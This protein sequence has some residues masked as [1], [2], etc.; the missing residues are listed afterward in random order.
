MDEDRVRAIVTGG[1]PKLQAAWDRAK[2]N[3]RALDSCA[4]PHAFVDITPEK[5]FGKTYRCS[6]CDGEADSQARHWYEL[7]L[8]HGGAPK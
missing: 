3:G 6:A 4:G 2:S 8:K 5:T 7:G 1:A